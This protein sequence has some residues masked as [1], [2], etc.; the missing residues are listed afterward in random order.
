MGAQAALCM[1]P[2]R[3]HAGLAA[4]PP[5]TTGQR[6]ARGTSSLTG[7]GYALSPR[8]AHRLVRAGAPAGLGWTAPGVARLLTPHGSLPAE[9]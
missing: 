7:P 9:V 4:A 6:A 1:A 2:P 3:T 5:L 8:A